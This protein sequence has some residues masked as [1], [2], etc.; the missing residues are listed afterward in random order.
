MIH[1]TPLLAR[2]DGSVFVV[3]LGCVALIGWAIRAILMRND[4][5]AA[6]KALL[7]KRFSAAANL[8]LKVAKAEFY[9]VRR[10]RKGTPQYERALVGLERVFLAAGR[11]ADFARIRDLHAD[12]ATLRA[13]KKYRSADALRESLNDDGWKI[14]TRIGTEAMTFFD[15]LPLL[16]P[17]EDN[18]KQPQPPTTEC[19]C[20]HCTS[21]LRLKSDVVGRIECVCPRCHKSF[22]VEIE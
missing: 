14:R 18:L 21:R 8:F 4:L 11:P 16:I 5:T 13:D 7:E 9:F 17:T 15:T 3:I 2:V 20:P 22:T 6:D 10:G 19:A 1:F 12:L